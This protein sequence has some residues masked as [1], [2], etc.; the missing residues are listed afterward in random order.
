MCYIFSYSF[1]CQDDIPI[2]ENLPR[3]RQEA[4]ESLIGSVIYES[5]V[6]TGDEDYVTARLTAQKGMHRAFFWAAAQAL[7]KYMKAFLLMRGKGVKTHGKH[8]IQNIFK[9][10]CDIHDSFRSMSLSPHPSIK[11]NGDLNLKNETITA[12]EFVLLIDKHGDSHNRYNESG[13]VFEPEL[14]FILDSF[15]SALR[16]LIGVPDIVVSLKK[17]DQSLLNSFY[18]YNP[19]FDSR[20]IE[21]KELPNPS[22]NLTFSKSSTTLERLYLPTP[23]WFKPDCQIAIEWLEKKMKISIKKQK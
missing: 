20:P 13:V 6:K 2:F 14:L 17:I 12:N 5:F 21:L 22:F 7:E 9:E 19:Y 8:S 3:E 10:V 16:P 1:K 18:L 23:P 15:I 4:V 11:I